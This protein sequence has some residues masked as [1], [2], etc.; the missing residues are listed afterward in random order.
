MV[1]KMAGPIGGRMLVRLAVRGALKF[2][3][4]VGLAANAALAYAYTYGLGKACC[5][6]FGQV[7]QG[8]APSEAELQRVWESQLLQAA[9]LWRKEPRP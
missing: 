4:F 9:Q 3:P 6:Y 7:C 2:V 8:N 5:W 1:L